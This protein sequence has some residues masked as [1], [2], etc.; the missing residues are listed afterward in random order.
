MP[1]NPCDIAQG[2]LQEVARDW[3]PATAIRAV[4]EGDHSH[5]WLEYH[6]KDH[7]FTPNNHDG[8]LVGF[9]KQKGIEFEECWVRRMMPEAVYVCTQAWEARQAGK[10]R[11]TWALMQA[12]TPVIAQA[13]L[14]WAPERIY[15]TPDL[16]VHT[17]WLKENEEALTVAGY[18][19]V[20]WASSDLPEH[21][22]VF[23]IKFKTGLDR[24]EKKQDWA[25]CS[26]QVR[27]YSYMLGHLQQFMPKAAYIIARDR[28]HNPYQA[29][30]TSTL[31][32]A[33][34]ADLAAMR[35]TVLDIKLNGAAYYPW[36]DDRT[37]IND[38]EDATWKSAKKQI[39][40]KKIEGRA[41][42]I[43]HKIGSK[44]RDGLTLLGYPSLNSLLAVEP[45]KVP[46]ESI[47][48]LGDT[49]AA[50]I[51]A[52][53]HANRDGKPRILSTS[54]VPPK[55]RKE[56]FVDYEYFTNLNVP[57]EAVWP[58]TTGCEMIFMIGVGWECDQ[59]Q[60]HWEKFIANAEDHHSEHLMVEAFCEFYERQGASFDP[61][62]T[63]LY[64]WSSAE[65]SQSRS[66]AARQG[67]DRNHP[68]CR[69]PWH[70]LSK[71]FS[72]TPVGMPG[73]W[74]YGL[75]DIAGALGRYDAEFDPQWPDQLFSGSEAMVLGWNAYASEK[76]LD[77]PQMT[78][79]I[80]YLEADCQAMRQALR[81]L[82]TK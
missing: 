61:A 9:V 73:A 69:L 52:V 33:L 25:F 34:D 64:H 81:W 31:G 5:L 13:A 56:L 42:E 20:A 67:Y 21:Y 30:V 82:R 3:M 35:D 43:L 7:G 12:N 47:K 10:V 65:V 57:F 48:G 72:D 54:K 78:E 23:D 79:I 55:K 45:E 51:R 49:S 16:L 6:G 40:E 50:Q 80:A 15:G 66:A 8:T 11:D 59:G 75:K 38:F 70:D 17:S 37:F 46:F 19:S 14:W 76:P 44:A 39:A 53:L 2:G 77:T 60:W 27:L 1:D 58:K 32:A 18:D 26:G 41:R 36:Q 63:V 28:T 22:V 74:K 71:T 29:P 62:D 4:C 68:L 24:T